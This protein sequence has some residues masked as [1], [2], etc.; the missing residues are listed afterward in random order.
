MADLDSE[1]ASGLQQAQDFRGQL[2]VGLKSVLAAVQSQVR[3]MLAH[4]RI[5]SPD[6]GCRNIGRVGDHQ[7]KALGIQPLGPVAAEKARP[8]G[9][10]KMGGVFLGD[11]QSLEADIHAHPAGQGPLAQDGQK[12][13]AGADAQIYHVEGLVLAEQRQ[14][15]IENSLGV[16]PGRQHVR[17]DRQHD[18]PKA[19]TADD[20]PH[21]LAPQTPLD[22]TVQGRPLGFGQGPIGVGDNV[23]AGDPGG[24]LEQQAR[25]EHRAI[26]AL[27]LQPVA[28][29]GPGGLQIHASG[30]PD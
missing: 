18:L 3:I 22:I 28:G 12:D 10:T 27:R 19:L 15:D 20:A 4:L 25:I 26:Q 1:G 6:H 17:I 30:G 5:Q 7:V 16:R 2:P 8:A 29:R 11:R 23:R 13:G 21:R 24:G 9:K 14:G